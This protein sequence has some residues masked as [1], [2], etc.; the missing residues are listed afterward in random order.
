M[1]KIVIYGRGE[2]YKTHKDKLPRNT[3]I[4]AYADSFEESA[5][6]VTGKLYEGKPV[7]LPSELESLKFDS[8]YICTDYT[9][10][11]R[12]FQ[13]LVENNI[14][15]DKILFLN[16]IVFPGTWEYIATEDGKGIISAIAGIRI[17]EQYLT[18]FDIVAEIFVRNI[19]NIDVPFSDYIVIDMGMNIGTASLYFARKPEV[20]RVYGFEPF[21]D[22]YRQALDN[23]ARNEKYIRDK[24][25]P[26]NVA[27]LNVEETRHVAIPFEQSGWRN[28]FSQDKEKAQIELRCKDA[29]KVVRGIVE[30]HPDQ[31]IILKCDVEGS[32]FK[33]FDSLDESLCFEKIDA[34]MMEVHGSP[35]PLT[36]IL[37]KYG[38]RFF[39][40]GEADRA[41][42]LYAVK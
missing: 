19:Y 31:K 1:E 20:C 22:T 25:V 39:V 11:N 27:L 6:S 41:Q 15:S 18:D 16:R 13:T 28:I 26:Y 17:K 3:E 30:K 24:I 42:M 14:S 2:Y 35:V 38:Y 7:L 23:F 12:I 40:L 9:A 10:G 37:K 36:K 5:T 21:P 4:L 34:I 29:G 33:I 8:V 32:E